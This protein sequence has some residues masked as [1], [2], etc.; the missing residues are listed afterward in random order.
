MVAGG[1]TRNSATPCLETSK[2][3]SYSI[4]IIDYYIDT[5]YILHTILSNC[6]LQ[7]GESH[8]E[9][10]LRIRHSNCF[11]CALTCPDRHM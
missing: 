1:N 4:H 5:M 2:L 11:L 8:L 7:A 6:L 10:K 9:V 3:V